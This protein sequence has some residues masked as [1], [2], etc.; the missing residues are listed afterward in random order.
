MSNSSLPLLSVIIP[1]FNRSAYLQKVLH[2]LGQQQLDRSLFELIV[3]DDG[4][5]DDSSQVVEAFSAQLAIHY[6]RKEHAAQATA[7]NLGIY[8]AK[9]EIL[10]FLD[11]DDIPTSSFLPELLN[12]HRRYPDPSV[13]VLAYTELSE[14]LKSDPLLVYVTGEGGQ[15][16]SYPALTDGEIYD[17]KTFWSGRIS[18]KRSFLIEGGIFNPIFSFLEDVELGWRLSKRGLKVVYNKKAR[19]ILARNPGF[20]GICQRERCKGKYHYLFG[21]LYDDQE[22]KE[23]S[24]IK[25][26]QKRWLQLY[27]FHENL[28]DSVKKLHDCLSLRIKEGG[29]IEASQRALLYESYQKVLESFFYKGMSEGAQLVLELGEK[30]YLAQQRHRKLIVPLPQ[31]GLPLLASM[32]LSQENY[33]RTLLD[34]IYRT[35]AKNIALRAGGEVDYEG[36]IDKNLAEYLWETIPEGSKTIEVDGLIATLIFLNKKMDH[37]VLLSKAQWE[38]PLQDYLKATNCFSHRLR[39]ERGPTEKILPGLEQM[40]YDVAILHGKKG[41]PYPFMEFLYLSKGLKEKGLLIINDNFLYSCALL[42]QSL[43]LLEKEWKLE[44]V[45]SG[46]MVFRKLKEPSQEQRE[47]IKPIDLWGEERI[48]TL[49]GP[50]WR[51]TFK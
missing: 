36:E 32:P 19:T 5:S 38:A 48:F 16:F 3:I 28:Y 2:A 11:D 40:G 9:G 17:W 4:G 6:V 30:G 31:K 22:V 44:K 8:L 39:I 15:Y 24:R 23:Y 34:E 45:F 10:V 49:L 46:A 37:T 20:E 29:S 47:S 42:C 33:S 26:W 50:Y 12:S 21:Y 25:D 1:T 41:F 13:A 7:R 27:P 14:R 18:V 35:Y 51:E 43:R